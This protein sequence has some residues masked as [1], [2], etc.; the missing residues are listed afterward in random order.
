MNL[1]QAIQILKKEV[2][3]DY[4]KAYLNALDEAIEYGGKDALKAQLRYI[5]E[6]SKGYRG[7]TAKEVKKVI[8]EYIKN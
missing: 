4:A 6:N 8:R 5:L 1:N 3:N 2:K 7:E